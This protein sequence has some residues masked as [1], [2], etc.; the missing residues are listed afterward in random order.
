MISVLPEEPLNVPYAGY[1]PCSIKE[2]FKEGRYEVKS[3][4]GWG[5]D[6]SVWLVADTTACV[7]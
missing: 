1:F 5:A 4:L 6:S 3:K 2:L 7:L